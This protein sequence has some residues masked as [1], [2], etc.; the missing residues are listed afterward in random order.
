MVSPAAREAFQAAPWLGDL[1]ATARIA[2]L[3]VLEE[4][5]VSPGS[6]LL[7]QGR[8]NDRII[9]QLEGTSLATR[10]YDGH[11]D[12]LRARLESPAI[13]GEISFF[14]PTPG[15]ATVRA[16]TAGAM[17]TC[18]DDN[19][20]KE[21]TPSRPRQMR[22]SSSRISRARTS[23]GAP[24]ALGGARADSNHAPG[25]CGPEV[26]ERAGWIRR[27]TPR[28]GGSGSRSIRWRGGG[29]CRARR[30]TP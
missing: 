24:P 21:V 17:V 2:L 10:H 7:L 27:L 28:R 6:E 26:I 4:H 22:T 25:G 1:D 18:L 3:N 9:F 14:R 20:A 13:Y 12:E 8:P 19:S 15:L 29:D 30:G 23:P 16:V 5:R 11:R